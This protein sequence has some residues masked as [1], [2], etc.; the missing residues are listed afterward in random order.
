MFHPVVDSSV[1]MIGTGMASTTNLMA[2]F[3][4][5]EKTTIL[6]S[7]QTGLSK[8][9]ELEN[10]LGD[11]EAEKLVQNFRAEL[12]FL[13]TAAEA[14]KEHKPRKVFHVDPD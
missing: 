9:D 5:K 7:I 10:R 2:T 6:S 1:E 8:L 12:N 3:E 14:S 4:A 13:K 11:K